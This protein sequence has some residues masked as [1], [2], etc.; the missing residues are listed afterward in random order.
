MEVIDV[1]DERELAFEARLIDGIV[2]TGP[3]G[4]TPEAGGKVCQCCGELGYY[5]DAA[6]ETAGH[7]ERGD[8][9]GFSEAHIRCRKIG[10]P[11]GVASRRWRF[12]EACRARVDVAGGKRVHELWLCAGCDSRFASHGLD[13]ER[14]LADLASRRWAA[15]IRFE[16]RQQVMPHASARLE[17]RQQ[18]P[19]PLT[20]LPR[21]L[22]ECNWCGEARGRTYRASGTGV[23][24]VESVC[25]CAGL[26]CSICGE[27]RIRRPITDYFDPHA[28]HWWHV[29]YFAAMSGRCHNCTHRRSPGYG[30]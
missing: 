24:E 11:A 17:K 9:L 15:R 14:C 22:R 7:S 18:D 30:G 4:W 12:C 21:G 8:F 26:I 1:T 10:R 29:P 25:F 5:E 6:G 13:A 3:R 28:R 27:R 20:R 19:P 23:K 16:P 2:A